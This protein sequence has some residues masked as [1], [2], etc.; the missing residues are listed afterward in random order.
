M[1]SAQAAA[2]AAGQ[3]RASSLT[4]RVGWTAQ[5]AELVLSGE[6]DWTTAPALCELL[7][8]ALGRQPRTLILRMAEI[9]SIDGAAV[10][11]IADAARL[12]PAVARMVICRPS[13]PVR[14]VLGES[15][16][17]TVVQVQ[18]ACPP[19]C[20]PATSSSNCSPASM[21]RTA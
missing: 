10:Q 6:L 1:L 19:G 15:G 2:D 11:V 17:D 21:I 8:L 16:L 18:E 14:T 7:A 13:L 20:R 12:L 9:R 3:R 5:S 4:A